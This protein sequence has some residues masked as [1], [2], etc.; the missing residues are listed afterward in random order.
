MIASGSRAPRPDFRNVRSY[1]EDRDIP[2]A[3]SPDTKKA[4]PFECFDLTLEYP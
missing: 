4:Q 1:R 3:G 2:I